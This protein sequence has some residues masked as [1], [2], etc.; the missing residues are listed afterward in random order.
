[1]LRLRQN[2]SVMLW[3]HDTIL[4]CNAAILAFSYLLSFIS[5]YLCKAGFSTLVHS[6]TNSCNRQGVEDDTSSHK[7]ITKNFLTSCTDASSF[8]PLISI[9][10]WFIQ[11]CKYSELNMWID[12]VFYLVGCYFHIFKVVMAG[13]RHLCNIFEWGHKIKKFRNS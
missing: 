4:V 8:I 13:A 2:I 10:V 6:E 5:N 12:S 9:P 1:M 11:E 7:Y 3:F